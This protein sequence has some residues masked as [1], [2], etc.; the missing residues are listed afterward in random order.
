[1]FETQN[2]SS[3]KDRFSVVIPV[4]NHERTVADVVRQT[5]T[6]DLPVVVVDD[7]STDSTYDRI[8]GIAGIRI[9]QHRWNC[10]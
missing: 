7:G 4:Y 10:G 8:K 1:M 9:L 3:I 5:L 2:G 6:L